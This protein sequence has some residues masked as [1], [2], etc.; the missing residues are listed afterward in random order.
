M[1]VLLGL[2]LSAAAGCA[3]GSAPAEPSAQGSDGS[4]AVERLYPASAAEMAEAVRSA[5]ASSDFTIRSDRHDA[6]GGEISGVRADGPR[7]T[8]RITPVDRERTQVS[9]WA[10]PANRPLAESIQQ[11]IAEK[12]G[13][14][15][16]AK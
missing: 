14:E 8:A 12:S 6:T 2:V 10:A 16:H 7:V 15:Y 4:S 3:A 9:V 11:R 13:G 5:F 1:R